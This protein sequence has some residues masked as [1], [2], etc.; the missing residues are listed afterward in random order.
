MVFGLKPLNVDNVEEVVDKLAQIVTPGHRTKVT[1]NDEERRPGFVGVKV[2]ENG[3]S[4]A[5]LWDQERLLLHAERE[6]QSC[7]LLV[8]PLGV[9][10]KGRGDQSKRR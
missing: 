7:Q 6:P 2:D 8:L 4:Q 3:A 10:C 5:F 1:A 9:S